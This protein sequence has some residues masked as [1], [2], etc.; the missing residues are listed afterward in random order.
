[1]VKAS[2]V[3][4]VVEVPEQV[5]V[6]VENGHV[7]VTG[8][9]GTLERD[10]AHAPLDIRVENGDIVLEAYWPDKR[11]SAM[12]GTIRSHIR[13]MIIGVEKGFT[14]KMKVVYAHFP[15]SVKVQETEIMIENFGGERRPRIIKISRDVDVSLQGDDVVLKGMDIEEVS[16]AAA[17]IQQGTRIKNKDPRVFLD[18]IYIYERQEGM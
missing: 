5:K 1:M 11:K 15:M 7:A 13:N 14:Y 16:Q 4:E 17:R 3:R 10:F 6:K 18:G 9:L 2:V 8:A 12:V